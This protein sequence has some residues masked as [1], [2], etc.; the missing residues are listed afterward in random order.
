MDKGNYKS[1]KI[2]RTSSGSNVFNLII[3]RPSH[4]NALSADFFI[5]FP[6][7]LSF[8]DQNPDVAVVILSGAG[9][10][11]CSGIDIQV[12][13]SN[14]ADRPLS[15]RGRVGEKL[16]RDIKFLQDAITAI[17][18][19]RKPVIVGVHGACVGGAVDI[20]TACDVRYCSKDAYFSV[21]EVDLAIT[22]DLGT[23]QRLPGIVGYGKAMELA[24]TGRQFSGSEAKEMG[25]VSKVFDTKEAME[26]G[27]KAIAE[28]KGNFPFNLN[29][30]S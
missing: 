28:G 17:E 3:N 10:H 22:A 8:L 16:R 5:E 27:I 9:R 14:F 29:K 6:Q 13:N 4:V 23:L 19:C 30:N 7:A 15:D 20:I 11:F 18:R 12:L 2:V 25:L 1:L 26:E 21:K 24:L